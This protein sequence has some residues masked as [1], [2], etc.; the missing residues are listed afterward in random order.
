[1]TSCFKEV[2]LI[3]ETSCTRV[4][5]A[6][7]S[8]MKRLQQEQLQ[9]EISTMKATVDTAR[10]ES[11]NPTIAHSKSK[12]DFFPSLPTLSADKS[13]VTSF[14]SLSRSPRYQDLTHA[15]TRRMKEMRS[16]KILL[17]RRAQFLKAQ[18]LPDP[19]KQAKQLIRDRK[20][21]EADVTE[22]GALLQ[23][24]TKSSSS[25][26]RLERLEDEAEQLTLES[27]LR[28]KIRS[29]KLVSSEIV[30]SPL[31]AIGNKVLDPIK[32]QIQMRKVRIQALLKQYL[33]EFLSHN[34]SQILNEML[35]GASVSVVKVESENFRK[36]Q[37]VHISVGPGGPDPKWVIDRLNVLSPKLRS[38]LATRI[39]LGHTPA[40]QFQLALD[41]KL[42]DKRRLAQLAKSAVSQKLHRSFEREMN[43]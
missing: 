42:F 24:V 29:E 26:K 1:M 27:R 19:A 20:S 9:H 7:Q 38:Q 28:A 34:S 4:F 2:F 6:R 12:T 15:E 3:S 43:W 30:N 22:G 8:T 40:L 39:N 31:P 17:D 16:R 14:E 23:S 5:L 25:S 10:R 13:R 18:S 41:T 36:T 21:E 37:K 11:M 33:E 35:G 32:R